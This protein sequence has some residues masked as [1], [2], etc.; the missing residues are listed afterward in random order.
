MGDVY[1]KR[2]GGPESLFAV[3]KA[4]SSES[5]ILAKLPA[6]FFQAR[7]SPESQTAKAKEHLFAVLDS[8]NPKKPSLLLLHDDKGGWYNCILQ[9]NWHQNPAEAELPL[10]Q[11]A[12]VLAYPTNYSRI[13]ARTDEF[14]SQWSEEGTLLTYKQSYINNAAVPAKAH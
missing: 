2:W 13:E 14:S 11:V 9:E 6:M 1:V 10:D 3:L 7:D 4:R 5:G 12:L 8:R